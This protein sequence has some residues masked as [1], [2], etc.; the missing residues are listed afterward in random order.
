[1]TITSRFDGECKVCGGKI[2]AGDSVEWTKG[3]KGV[4]HAVCPD[5][6]EVP[7]ATDGARGFVASLLAEA[8]LEDGK[9]AVIQ[10]RLDSTEHPLTK[11]EASSLIDYLKPLPK[12]ALTLTEADVPEGRYAV[13]QIDGSTAFVKVTWRD[14]KLGVWDADAAYGEKGKFYPKVPMVE[15]IVR[16]GAADCAKRYGYL[17]ARCS[18]CHAKLDVKLSVELGIGPTCG[19]YWHDADEWKQIKRDAREAI[20]ARGEDP[21]DSV[22]DD[23]WGAA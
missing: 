2:A 18:R 23:E 20:E 15:E 8:E 6:P 5:A 22:T 12:R 13:M 10:D 4:A 7:V 11:R 1:M 14:G 16:Q 9:R 17:R 21:D 3:E 19:K